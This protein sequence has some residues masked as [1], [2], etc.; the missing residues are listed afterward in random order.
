MVLI[1]GSNGF[2]GSHLQKLL[3]TK[4][5]EY[6]T[7]KGDLLDVS[8]IENFFEKNPNFNKIIHLVGRFLP[9]YKDQ[10]DLN[11]LAL[12]NLL[13]VAV[14][15]NIKNLIFTSTSAVYGSPQ[16]NKPSLESDDLRPVNTYGL[17]K[18]QAEE[19]VDFYHFNYGLQYTILR[20]ASIY[21]Q[22]GK[23]VVDLFLNKINDKEK[24][25]IEGNGQQT[26][27]F[28]FVE[29]V[30]RA[31]FLSLQKPL[32]NQVFN[33]ADSKEVSIKELIN[34]L[35]TQF[36]FKVTKNLLI[37]NNLLKNSVSTKKAQ[38]ELN[39]VTE[40]NLEKYIQKYA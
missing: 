24:L 27:N 14:K 19:V 22:G 13:S 8:S 20:L 37:N 34:I 21:G 38:K 29:D 11:V 17:S 35:K 16:Q 5:I 25:T 32:S 36:D 10:L 15:N 18:K 40:T 39:F 33:I 23:G 28:I 30:C 4:K 3:K 1:T 7:F 31:I 6:I 12:D 2:V 9:P 26:R